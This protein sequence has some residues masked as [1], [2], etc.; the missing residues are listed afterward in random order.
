MKE[1]ILSIIIGAGISF[2]MSFPGEEILKVLFFSFLGGIMG[3]VGNSIC[4]Y[5]FG[6]LTQIVRFLISKVTLR[7]QKNQYRRKD[8]KNE[9]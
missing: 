7:N 1:N 2:V 4:K 9:N 6:K 8:V 3:F 5:L